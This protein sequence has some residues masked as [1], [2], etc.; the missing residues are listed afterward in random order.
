LQNRIEKCSYELWLIGIT[1]IE[2][3]SACSTNLEVSN[4]KNWLK[5]EFREP[6]K[7]V[8]HVQE[9]KQVNQT[10]KLP[11]QLQNGESGWKKTI[12]Q[13]SQE[14]RGQLYVCTFH[15][16][17]NYYTK[18]PWIQFTNSYFKRTG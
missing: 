5:F 13:E 9:C 14:K 12:L 18:M 3:I 15:F 7:V 6:K 16:H 17:M 10:K 11:N 1:S 4:R 2:I 8:K